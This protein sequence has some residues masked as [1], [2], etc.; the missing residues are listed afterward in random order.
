VNRSAAQKELEQRR[1]LGRWWWFDPQH[2]KEKCEAALAWELLRR[3]KSY[4]ALWRKY[5]KDT[6]PLLQPRG[7]PTFAGAIQ[8]IHH[9]QRTRDA[10]GSP[11]FD[12]MMQGFDPALAWVE[13]DQG[14]RLWARGFVVGDGCAIKANSEQLLPRQTLVLPDV[15]VGMV[16]LGPD[17][18]DQ[19]VL[20]RQVCN[21]FSVGKVA[22]T[23][24]F[25][26][27]QLRAGLYLHVYFD[28]RGAR[29]ALVEALDVEMQRWLGTPA[30][31]EGTKMDA[32]YWRKVSTAS[33]RL[34]IQW[35][36]RNG[37]GGQEERIASEFWTPKIHGSDNVRVP[38][39]ER[40]IVPSEMPA[41]AILLVSARH[42]PARVRGVFQ[43]QLKAPQFRKWH[44]LCVEFWKTL[45]H[46]KMGVPINPDG[47]LRDEVDA[48][49]K[50]I[51]ERVKIPLFRPNE[52][53]PSLRK[54]VRVA[55]L[56]EPWLGLAANDVVLEK[57]PLGKGSNEGAFLLE[58]SRSYHALRNA[59]RSVARRLTE[60]DGSAGRLDKNLGHWNDESERLASSGFFRAVAG[61]P[62]DGSE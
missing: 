17:G 19:M 27:L 6:I 4:T 38:A 46:E 29:D 10:L 50:M 58:R 21:G 37:A 15:G 12:F 31:A 24:P 55:W 49:G 54:P 1:F 56:K 5:Q 57:L 30:P 28:T 48:Q 47:S 32:S 34:P 23:D 42:N 62:A 14:R 39:N 51:Y 11:Y 40:A 9:F 43:T 22:A 13:L 26:R 33:Q 16:E 36:L 44:P 59:Q 7:K 18:S 45:F 20:L 53:L 3:T 35:Q 25:R 2:D 61:D 8:H 60:L 41:F 52:H